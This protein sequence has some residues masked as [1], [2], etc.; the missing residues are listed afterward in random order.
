M[1]YLISAAR[2]FGLD[3]IADYVLEREEIHGIQIDVNPF[4]TYLYQR[5]RF[6][7][8]MPEN[9][10]VAYHRYSGSL[11]DQRFNEFPPLE[12]IPGP[13]NIY[14]QPAYWS[15]YF[16]HHH[17]IVK[18]LLRPG[19]KPL[20]LPNF[21]TQLE[22]QQVQAAIPRMAVHAKQLVRPLE[23]GVSTGHATNSPGTLGGILRDK[24]GNKY[25][26]T[27]GHVFADAGLL[28]DQPSQVD[29]PAASV[30]GNC[31]Y[32]KIP[33][34][35]SGQLCNPRNRDIMLNDMDLALVE[36]NQSITASTSIINI[37]HLHG[38]TPAANLTPRLL[39]EMQGRTS[40]HRSLELGGI[41]FVQEIIDAQG[42]PCCFENLIQVKHTSF[43]KLLFGRPV[44]GGDSGSWLV[45]QGSHGNEWC[46]MI[47]SADRLAGYALMSEDIIEHLNNNGYPGLSCI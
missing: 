33:L 41:G 3:R 46:G 18:I 44:Q 14:W 23:G 28:V 8:N 30:I 10:F 20:E 21:N 39:V 17:L 31:L 29:D 1:K 27:C 22:I 36:L 38:L 15:D 11:F 19:S 4:W 25:G 43:A 35:T 6:E 32:S 16:K 37:G 40:G 7:S 2:E 13:V 12:A 47:I 42:N 26:V 24:G 5:Y 34:S 9:L 45:T